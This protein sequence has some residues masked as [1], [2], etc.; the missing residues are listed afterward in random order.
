MLE[1]LLATTKTAT[2]KT[3]TV[4]VAISHDKNGSENSSE[5]RVAN[6]E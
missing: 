6:S 2:T 1:W 4:G 5:W 3:A